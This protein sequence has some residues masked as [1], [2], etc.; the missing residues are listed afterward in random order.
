MTGSV[1]TGSN[2]RTQASSN[3]RGPGIRRSKRP[4]LAN[5]TRSE[6]LLEFVNKDIVGNKIQ[7]VNKV[8]WLFQRMSCNVLGEGTSY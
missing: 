6:N 8:I 3:W 4:L 7:F 2:I 1:E 5:N